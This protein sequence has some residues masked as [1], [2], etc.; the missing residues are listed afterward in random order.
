MAFPME[1]DRDKSEFTE[2]SATIAFKGTDT[3]LI[4]PIIDELNK[5]KDV[6]IVRFINKHP[7]LED[8]KLFV[9]M[10][11]GS[12]VDAIRTACDAVSAFFSECKVE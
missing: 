6:K 11:Q 5:N 12:P 8:T 1:I 7:E 9:E 2:T 10:R 3:T 4:I